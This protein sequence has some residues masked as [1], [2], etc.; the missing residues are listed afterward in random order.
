MNNIYKGKYINVELLKNDFIVTRHNYDSNI[1]WDD[2]ATELQGILTDLITNPPQFEK[3]I[4]EEDQIHFLQILNKLKKNNTK[5]LSEDELDELALLQFHREKKK[6]KE[7]VKEEIPPIN[8]NE[9]N[10]NLSGDC[11]L[12]LEQPKQDLK[13]GRDWGETVKQLQI[14]ATL[15]PT[16]QLIQELKDKSL[17]NGVNLNGKSVYLYELTNEEIDQLVVNKKQVSFG[18]IF[19]VPK[20]LTREALNDDNIVARI[21]ADNVQVSYKREEKTEFDSL[22]GIGGTPR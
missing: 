3:E 8:I 6:T 22:K 7:A 1:Q 11:T 16:Y 9:T 14:E 5:N 10:S 18:K 15:T 20:M 12:G 19:E 4:S 2:I 21:N 17:S 13:K